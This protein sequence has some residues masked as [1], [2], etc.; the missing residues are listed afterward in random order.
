MELLALTTGEAIVLAGVAFVAGVV[1]GFTGFALSALVMVAAVLILPPIE[2]IPMLW[3]LEMTASLLMVRSGWAEA[4]RRVAL[5]LVLT[6]AIGLPIGLVLTM[7]MSLAASALVALSVIVVLSVAQLARVRL[8]FLGTSTG[9]AGAGLTAG[10]VTGLSGAGGMV[11]ALCVL[12]LNMPARVIRASLVLY[13][14]VA[15]MV[16]FMTHVVVGTM[17][18]A[19]VARG[20]AFAL[21]TAAGVLLGKALFVPRYERYYKPLCL[22][23][24]IA[25]AMAGILRELAT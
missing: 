24:L 13:L 23:L 16:G 7:S 11:V 1:R 10:I 8:A 17:D 4:D 19:A 21:P 20:L 6:S 22:G 25:L 5:R 3:W 12:A 15:L 9:L 14:F 18:S 2:L